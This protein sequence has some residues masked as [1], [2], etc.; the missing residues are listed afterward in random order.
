[1]ARPR[2][3]DDELRQRLLDRTSRIVTESGVGSLSLRTL[4]AAE[5]TST[6]AVY[7]LFGGKPA[8]LG[9]LYEEA[10]SSFGAAQQA[11]DVTT[12][13][14]ADLVALG[15]AY[16]DWALAHPLL[17]G[18]MFGGAL[19][20]F[21]PDVKQSL[22]AAT[23]ITPL[24]SAVGRALSDGALTGDPETITLAIW[25]GVHGLVSLHLANCTPLPVAAAR[26]LFGQSMLAILRGWSTDAGHRPPRDGSSRAD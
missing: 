6:S 10:F 19:A 24:Q 11:V 15:W 8:L 22:R 26:G 18:V 16:W 21:T 3:H 2:V 7:S 20:G 17:Y 13:P 23:T 1:V 12:D 4:A 14:H 5:S 25:A 9:A